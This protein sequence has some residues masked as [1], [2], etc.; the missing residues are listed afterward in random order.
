M[1]SKGDCCVIEMHTPTCPVKMANTLQRP[2]ANCH[3]IVALR[4]SS[5]FGF[6]RSS[7]GL[8]RD[9]FAVLRYADSLA[10]RPTPRAGAPD[11]RAHYLLGSGA[12]CERRAVFAAR[13]NCGGLAGAGA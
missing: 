1:S 5:G 2:F 12:L 8:D 13:P 10:L 3:C 4:L 11:P 9:T 7:K 6:S